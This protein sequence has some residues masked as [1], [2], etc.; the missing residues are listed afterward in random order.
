MFS[1]H[2]PLD[3]FMGEGGFLLLFFLIWWFFLVLF[4]ATISSGVP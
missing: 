1:Q 2:F 3:V 4:V